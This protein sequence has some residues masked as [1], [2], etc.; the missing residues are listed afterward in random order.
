MPDHRHRL[1]LNYMNNR[2]LDPYT[3]KVL[4]GLDEDAAAAKSEEVDLA[5]ARAQQ[6]YAE[7]VLVAEGLDREYVEELL[8]EGVVSDELR[9]DPR[10]KDVQK[11]MQQQQVIDDLLS[12]QTGFVDAVFDEY[13]TNLEDTQQKELERYLESNAAGTEVEN[14]FMRE[15]VEGLYEFKD[16]IPEM[17][18]Q[19][20]EL[21]GAD[22]LTLEQID[23]LVAHGTIDGKPVGEL[24]AE[25]VDSID[26]GSSAAFSHIPA[27]TS[28][29][30][31]TAHVDESTD[32]TDTGRRI[33]I[34][35]QAAPRSNNLEQDFAPKLHL[36]GSRGLQDIEKPVGSAPASSADSPAV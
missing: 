21:A 23:E 24:P 11:V 9:S 29:V 18:Q 7:E 2:V 26:A 10:F 1:R 22:T 25:Q 32:A 3:I 34:V 20:K 4:T 6:I 31:T 16:K 15:L 35:D 14:E 33:N 5:I 8:R 12:I 36:G 13:K 30:V 19:I 28:E 17:Q 27:N